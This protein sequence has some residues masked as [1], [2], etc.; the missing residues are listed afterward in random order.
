M[1]RRRGKSH[2]V[3]ET[4]GSGVASQRSAASQ[5][6]A[7][8][9]P[10]IVLAAIVVALAVVGGGWW[11]TTSRPARSTSGLDLGR[12]TSGARVSDLNLLVITLDT[13]RA[14]RLGAYG[15]K[16]I[17]TPTLDRLAREGVLF[18]QTM[19]TAPLTLPA[20]CSIFTSKFPPEHGVRD[21]GGFFL[22]PNQLTLATFLKRKGLTTGAVVGAYVLDGKWGLNQGFDAYVDDFDLSKLSGFALGDVQRVGSEVVDRALPWLEKVK[23]QRFFAW[24]HFYDPH[25]PYEAPEPFRSR[26]ADHPYSGEIAYMDSQIGRVV[27]FLETRGLLDRT[28]IAVMGDHGEGI[29][30]HKEGTHGFFIYESTM[31]VPFIIR[32][33]F[34]RLRGRRVADPV[35]SVDL[36]PTVLD[37]MGL[38]SPK[39]IAGVSLTP[40][41]NGSRTTLDLEGYAEALYPLHHFGWSELRAWRAGRYKAIDAPRPELYDLERDP[42]ETTNLYAE[43]RTMA[44]GMIARLREKEKDTP[45]AESASKPT[46]EVDPEARARLAAL[47][48]VGSFV[49][50]VTGPK[51]DR[52]DPKD[53][54]EL[55]NLMT[56]AREV[57]KDEKSFERVVAMYRKV[58]ADDPNVIDAWFNLGNVYYRNGKHEEAISYFKRALELKPDYDLPVINMANAYRRMG[59][60]DAALAGYEHYLT[61]DPKNAHVRY[62]VG[63]IYLDKGDETRAEQNFKQ[64]LEIDPKEASALNALGVIAF[65][66]GD[67][68]TAEREA[69]AALDIKKDVRLAHYNLALIAEERHDLAAAETEYRKELE[70]HPNAY[71]AAFNLGRL[72]ERVG[73]PVEQIA[74]LKQAVD[75]NPRFGEG[76]VF[77][78]KAYLDTGTNFKEAIDLA[79]RGI[80]LQPRADI[81]ALG[82]YVLADLYNRVSR[83]QDAAREVGLGRAIDGRGRSSPAR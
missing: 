20:H 39:G 4:A 23:G 52:A 33:P 78:A 29:N 47:G 22:S 11:W 41:M 36:F 17:E 31:R 21:N 45:S 12:V 15:F 25:T 44:D 83:P 66:H 8:R 9:P 77:L 10:W 55:F 64:A 35:R 26:Y 59:K 19:A 62:Q 27:E 38:P 76:W 70:L 56:D 5:P 63:E 32:A 54:I 53:K 16:N 80:D 43:R 24:L 2:S 73:K 7:R 79:K 69:R 50:T 40:L 13:T 58:V 68:A 3:S 42:H 65:T 60:D 48:Y 14:D 51:S 75:Q 34:D 30:Q 1:V 28:I 46:P 18:E 57:A 49:A 71:K 6:P 72:Y 37:L 61:I 67:L 74:S 81:A 82:H